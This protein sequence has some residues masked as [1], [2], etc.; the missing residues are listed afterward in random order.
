MTRKRFHLLHMLLSFVGGALAAVVILGLLVGAQ[1]Y[2]F[3][4]ALSLVKLRFVADYDSGRALDSA[5][6]GY[7]RGL[8]DRWSYYLDAEGYADQTQ[9]RTNTYVGVGV[10]VTYQDERGLLLA[11]VQPSGPA[12]QAGL[13]AGEIVTAVDGVSIAGQARYDA[14]GLIL[15]ERG[16]RVVL[17]VLNPSGD[18]RDVTLTRTPV[19]T[20]PVS[21]ELLEDGTGYIRLENFYSRSAE[22]LS[23]AADELA[24]QGAAGLVFDMRNNGGGYVDELTDMLDHLLPEGVI[25]RTRGREGFERAVKSDAACV[26]L[27][28]AVLVNANTYS[29]AEFFAAQLQEAAGAKIVGE[30]TSG[31]GYSQQT[32]PLPNGGALNISTAEYRTGNG[33]SLIG[34]G[35]T[36]DAQVALSEEENALLAAGSLRREEDPQLQAALRLLKEQGA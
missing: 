25:F 10:T 34:A 6:D 33:V 2:T 32:F 36:L 12:G 3:L 35:V 19:E 23:A 8:G 16:T 13:T 18:S 4:G 14:T 28:M 20:Q 22:K 31:K 5:L 11:S 24:S 9:R 27:P 1:G 17:T 15:G 26:A 21:Y 29:A 30:E 7:V